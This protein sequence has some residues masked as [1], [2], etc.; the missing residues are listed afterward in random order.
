MRFDAD[1]LS[2]KGYFSAPFGARAIALDERRQLLLCGNIATGYVVTMDLRSGA[3]VKRYYLGPWLR[4]I[5]LRVDSGTAYISSNGALYRLK[6]APPLGQ[7]S[8]SAFGARSSRS[9]RSSSTGQHR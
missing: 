5:T 8:A 4:T 7:S 6:Y 3:Q 1:N 2:P 9:P